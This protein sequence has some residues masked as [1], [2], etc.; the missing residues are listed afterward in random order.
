[1][2]PAE[3]NWGITGLFLA[4]VAYD[5]YIRRKIRLQLEES[6]HLVRL[7]KESLTNYKKRSWEAQGRAYDMGFSDGVHFEDNEDLKEEFQEELEEAE[8]QLAVAI[9]AW[10]SEPTATLEI[11]PFRDRPW[12]RD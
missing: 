11:Y 6:E 10:K 8:H 4:S 9:E 7:L 12:G 1:M 5:W 2:T 3:W